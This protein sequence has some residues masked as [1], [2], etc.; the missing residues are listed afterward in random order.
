M[1]AV[2]APNEF[3]LPLSSSSAAQSQIPFETR[4]T[5]TRPPWSVLSTRHTLPTDGP[6]QVSCPNCPG[7]VIEYDSA[8]GNGFCV[9]CGTVVEENTIVAEV[10]FTE[11]A[12]GA[13]MVQGAYVALG[14]SACSGYPVSAQTRRA[15][16]RPRQRVPV[17]AASSA[18]AR[19]ASH[20]RLPSP[21]VSVRPVHTHPSPSFL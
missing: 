7:T 9:Q 16:T 21:P 14:A 3:D 19:A 2:E 10:G 18:T 13:A 1:R 15:E 11:G 12:N 6:V 17:W 5:P 4:P 20:A 8:A